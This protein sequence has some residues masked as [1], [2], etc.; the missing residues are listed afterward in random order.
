MMIL[1]VDQYQDWIEQI[2]LVHIMDASHN[3]QTQI[4]VWFRRFSRRRLKSICSPKFLFSDLCFPAHNFIPRFFSQNSRCRTYFHQHLW[5]YSLKFW[6]KKNMSAIITLLLA[7]WPFCI[8]LVRKVEQD[9]ETIAYT[10]HQFRHILFH[11]GNTCMPVVMISASTLSLEW[12][13]QHLIFYYNK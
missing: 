12:I 8:L 2:T 3:S 4:W 13:E 9:A 7:Q 10:D 5:I 6:K 11:H 1:P